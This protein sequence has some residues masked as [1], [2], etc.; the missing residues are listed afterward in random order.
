M[1]ARWLPPAVL[2][3]AVLGLGWRAPGILYAAAEAKP[4]QDELVAAARRPRDWSAERLRVL[5]A[6]A[7]AVRDRDPADGQW[8]ELHGR[9]ALFAASHPRMPAAESA[10]LTEAAIASFRNAVQRRPDWPY[11]HDGLMLAKSAAGQ[12]DDEWRAAIAAA[13]RLGPNES[14]I[15]EDLAMVRLLH[16]PELA[17]PLKTELQTLLPRLLRVNGSRW[18]DI[19]DRHDEADWLCAT[20]GLLAEVR[21]RCMTLGWLSSEPA[22]R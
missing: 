10:A 21:R 12:F 16:G 8:Q 9:A 6:D 2:L 19:A 11:G 7:A 13:L 1:T 3:A 14:R 4:V 22:P 20:P 17:E 5:V 15:R 18:V